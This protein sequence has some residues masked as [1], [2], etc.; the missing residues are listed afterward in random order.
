M[1]SFVAETIIQSRDFKGKSRI[2]KTLLAGL[3]G[4]YLKSRYGPKMRSNSS[5][6][7]NYACISGMYHADYDDVFAEVDQLKPNMAFIDIG[8][9]AGLFSL[10]ASGRVG[11]DGVVVAFEPSLPIFNYL[12]SNIVANGLTNVFPFNAAVG[13]VSGVQHFSVGAANHSGVSHLSPDGEQLVAVLAPSDISELLNALI[14]QRRVM[15][16]I[17]VEGAEALVLDGLTD[18]VMGGQVDMLVVEIDGDNLSKFGSAPSNVYSRMT[19]LG[20]RGRRGIR[21]ADHYNEV[22]ER[23]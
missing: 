9:N 13:S 3:D 6:F 12:V 1:M 15:I 16:K 18:L 10:V 14:G 17:D 7:T 20:Y 8:A 22:F 2:L 21:A 11:R 5:D 4:K 23:A 19:E